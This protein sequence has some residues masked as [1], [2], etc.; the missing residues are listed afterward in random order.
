[1]KKLIQILGAGAAL[2]TV[3]LATPATFAASK[4]MAEPKIDFA[5]TEVEIVPIR[6]NIYMLSAAGSN[7]TVQT[8]P[9]GVLVVDTLYG[10]LSDK[11]LAAIRTL[12]DKPIRYV[13]DTN[14]RIDHVGG[15][16]AIR[17]AGS[18]I[19]GGNVAF[20][21]SDAAEGAAIVS[22]ETVLNRL[23]APTG[24]TAAMPAEGWPTSTYFTG[25][26]DIYFNN[27]AVRIYHVPA[28]ATD[29]DSIVF[30]RKSDVIACGDIFQTTT[31]PIIDLDAGGSLQGL[32]DGETRLVG[33]MVAKYG[34]S[35]GTLLIPGHGR[36]AE[37]GDLVWYREMLAIVR[38]RIQALIDKG[39]T[40]KEVIAAKPTSDYDG[41][42]AAPSGPAT[43]ENFVTMVY[44]SLVTEKSAKKNATKG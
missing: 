11:V 31:Y 21:I 34:E 44:R 25:G 32:I 20:D 2:A 27:E 8:G 29:G 15:N 12:S 37:M 18:T 5:K 17:Q 43:A 39:M 35:G 3:L 19:T 33:M 41:R 36:A 38:D 24:E 9:D 40:L 10:E 4:Q 28:A 6:D 26:K 14:Y 23:S 1:M 16:A 42:Y 22:F 30:F 13:I 7:M